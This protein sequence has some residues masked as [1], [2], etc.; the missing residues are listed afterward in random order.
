MPGERCSLLHHFPGANSAGL[1]SVRPTEVHIIG[2]SK[3]LF[4]R[5]VQPE[6]RATNQFYRL[7][8]TYAAGAVLVLS[9]GV[10]SAR[11]LSP[12]IEYLVFHGVER[13]HIRIR[14]PDMDPEEVLRTSLSAGL[15]RT[16]LAFGADVAENDDGLARYFITTPSF[17]AVKSRQKHVVVGPKGSGKSAILRELAEPVSECLVI[18][19]EHYATDVLDALIKTGG[20]AEFAAYVSTWKYTLL[21]EIFRRLVQ[22]RGGS[23]GGLAEIRRYLVDHGH[24]NDELS[25]FERFH[26]YLRRITKVRGKV[27]PAEAEL[28]LD[29]AAELERLFKMDELLNLFPFLRRALRRTPF[30]V[31][32]DE[33]DQSWNNTETANRFLVSLLTAAIQLRGIDPNLHVIIFLRAEIFDLLKPTIAQLD[34]LRSD[35]EAIQWSTRDLTTLIVNRAFD[36]LQIEPERLSANT[37][38]SILFPGT[39][40]A[41][42]NHPLNTYSSG[43]L[44]VHAR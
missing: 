36:S 17:L 3:L 41:R 28:G 30:T 10:S 4:I 33:L 43:R 32:I 13:T 1:T 29:S 16:S 44:T 24:L 21:I 26:A 14:Y 38:I 6:L 7:V 31:F 18:T 2:H 19:P 20:N 9:D 5:E 12:L 34:K 8:K 42:G 25:L 23:A 27:G 40:A 22:N 35:I 37:A 11:D 15:Q 39:S